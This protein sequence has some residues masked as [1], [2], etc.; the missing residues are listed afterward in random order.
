MIRRRRLVSGLALL[1]VAAPIWFVAPASAGGGGELTVETV[2]LS[3]FPEVRLT[4]SPPSGL[5]GQTIESDSFSVKE[6]NADRDVTVTRLSS[7][8]LDVVIVV[9]TSGSM[10]GA[11][12]ISAQSSA[13]SFVEGLPDNTNIA[14]VSFGNGPEVVST[15]T[16]DKPA[17][18]TAIGSLAA[19]GDTAL[20]DGVEAA[21]GL[22][23]ASGG[24]QGAVVVLSDG[25]DTTSEAPLSRAAVA[26]ANTG[27]GL[28]VIELVTDDSDRPA[29]DRLARETGGQVLA[30]DDPT[31]LETTYAG[32]AARLSN[33]YELSFV[34]SG[35]VR[36]DVAVSVD[37]GGVS[38]GVL[39]P[40][41][42]P[43]GFTGDTPTPEP[44]FATVEPFV[45]S[46]GGLAA[47]WLLVAG[48]A[49]VAV[50]VLGA[51]VLATVG[52]EPQRR[53]AREYEAAGVDDET[54]TWLRSTADRATSFFGGLVERRGQARSIDATLDSAGLSLRA[55]EFVAFIAVSCVAA[56]MIGYLLFGP[57]GLVLALVPGLL[58]PAVL[59]SLRARRQ[60]KFSDQ[61]GEALL[62]LA[63]SLRA[64]FGLVQG[65]D[66]VARESDPPMSEEFS[67]VVVETRLGRGLDEALDAAAERVDSEDFRW[68]VDAME[69]H[70]EIGG[71]LAEVL[72]RVGD[73]IR[74]RA[75]ARRQVQALSAE[76]KMSA[77]VLVAL[78]FA[79]G[80]LLAVT[81]PDYVGELFTA[82][83]GQIMLV[84][85]GVLLVLGGLWLR[86]IIRPEF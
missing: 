18:A 4:V 70:R 53:L 72:D 66:S 33:L 14:L 78:P 71:D 45:E 9:D 79:V 40:L 5:A 48:A 12:I 28:T 69:I 44:E 11:P 77:V 10:K 42:Y 8:E 59:S 32:I 82:T 16:T 47:P 38:G 54:L 55:A 35:G 3:A 57:V 34:S 13:L 39:K 36:A 52:N 41:D 29:L 61:L 23:A 73:T 64:G 1:L 74:A 15:F 27:A 56:A 21:A 76:G 24:N 51:L 83:A 81:N 31:A 86:R 62:L 75:R 30:V 25:A 17:I 26:L 60:R 50:G 37:Q 67:R 7:D 58:A 2:D 65:V 49:L 46:G 6:N 85:A 22:L 20:Y 84:A 80:A 63:G 43:V 68:V 19:A